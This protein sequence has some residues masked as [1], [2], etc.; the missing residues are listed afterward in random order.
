M[1]RILPSLVT[2]AIFILSRF[3]CFFI[4]RGDR[5]FDLAGTIVIAIILFI[6]SCY[7]FGKIDRN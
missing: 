5:F 4:T 1:K 2:A 7:L 3:I 6:A